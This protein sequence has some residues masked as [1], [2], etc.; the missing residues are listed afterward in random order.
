M[1]T[2]KGILIISP[3]F[4]PNIGGVESHLDD[5]V[6]GLSKKYRVYVLTY[7]PITTADTSWKKV[8]TS[9]HI[10]IRR[11]SWFGKNIFHQ[12]EKHPIINFLYLTPYLF[13]RSYIWLLFNQQKIDYIHTHGLNA[14]IIGNILSLCFNKKHLNS[15]HAIYE[16]LPKSFVSKLSAFVYNHCD[17]VLA[18]SE[19]S[20]KQLISW[21]VKKNKISFYRHWIDLTRF[22]P[23]SE[24]PNKFTVLFVGRLIKKKGTRLFVS[25]AKKIPEADFYIIGAGPEAEYLSHVKLKN[26]NFIGKI[27]NKD[28]PQ[29]FKK[30]SIFC[31][32]VTYQEGFSRTIMEAVSSG[33]PVVATNMGTI[34]EIVS[35][36]VSILTKCSVDSLTKAIKSLIKN[37]DLYIKLRNNTRSFAR[38]NYS[39]KNLDLI[40]KHFS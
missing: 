25:I 9:K 16:Y 30:A 31:S 12:L 4:S 18:Q 20:K 8:E 6:K 35:P 10:Y 15:T 32:P 21:G 17:V 7:S 28:I 3:F 27:Q 13:V 19:F 34:P 2:I 14:A 33:L 29:Y 24:P 5:L 26:F 36:E 39:L 38:K 23:A 22:Q 1:A 37:P 40:T 11:F